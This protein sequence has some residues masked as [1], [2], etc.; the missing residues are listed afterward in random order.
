MNLNWVTTKLEGLKEK[1]VT[2]REFHFREFVLLDIFDVG[3]I[4]YIVG[5]FDWY[6]YWIDLAKDVKELLDYMIPEYVIEEKEHDRLLNEIMEMK[7][8]VDKKLRANR[9]FKEEVALEDMGIANFDQT[10]GSSRK[11]KYDYISLLVP[12]KK[13]EK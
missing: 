12:Y 13:K 3:K 2:K 5:D 4:D 6:L 11:I 10:D 7:L 1:I 9:H 8:I